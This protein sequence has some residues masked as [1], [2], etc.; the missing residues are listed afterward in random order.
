MISN[1]LLQGCLEDF[2]DIVRLNMALYDRNGA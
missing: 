1:R 2:S